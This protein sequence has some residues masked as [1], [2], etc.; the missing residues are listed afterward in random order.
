[1]WEW[2]K[3]VDEITGMRTVV[4]WEARHVSIETGTP[5]EF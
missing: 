3:R 2:E 5:F 4:K 1:M